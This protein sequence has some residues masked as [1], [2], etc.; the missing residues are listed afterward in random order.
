MIRISNL[1]RNTRKGGKT[2]KRVNLY[3][4]DEI[5][6]DIDKEAKKQNISRSNLIRKILREYVKNRSED[7]LSNRFDRLQTELKRE[8]KKQ[9]ERISKL[10]VKAALYSIATRAELNSLLYDTADDKE[11]AERQIEAAWKFAVEQLKKDE[12]L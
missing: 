12:W 10:T 5:L 4:N 9:A 3:L 11:E 2:V 8:I 6:L 7:R 1:L